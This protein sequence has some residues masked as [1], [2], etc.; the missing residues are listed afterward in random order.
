MI[1]TVW[2]NIG[3][4]MDIGGGIGVEMLEGEVSIN[5]WQMLTQ[6]VSHV[7]LREGQ[8]RLW[9][10]IDIQ[11]M[12]SVGITRKFIDNQTLLGSNVATRWCSLLPRKVNIFMWRA[13]L[14]KLPT[15]YNLSRKGIEIASIMCPVCGV[16]M[17]SLS[18]VLFTCTLAKEV[19]NRMYNWCQV[20]VRD[21][22]D[23]CEWFDWCDRNYNVRD[24]KVKNRGHRDLKL[25]NLLI[26]P[27]GHIKVDWVMGTGLA[28]NCNN[29][30][31]DAENATSDNKRLRW[32]T[33]VEVKRTP[34]EI[35]ALIN[36][37]QKAE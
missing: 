29:Q 20:D 33:A 2:F 21:I 32:S 17:E 14:N 36:N 8:D 26:G 11:G 6:A 13:R 28:E 4:L 30:I 31:E 16:S 18:H 34:R 5:S 25:D 9:W 24:R 35:K 19:W 10:D 23:L 1:K 12:F 15:R 27:D 37:M 22:N 7:A 3:G